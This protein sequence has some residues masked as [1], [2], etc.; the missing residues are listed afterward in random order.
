MFNTVLLTLIE[1][2][3]VSVELCGWFAN[4]WKL[5]WSSSI[6]NDSLTASFFPYYLRLFLVISCIFF[7]M[8][9]KFLVTSIRFSMVTCL[10]LS[11][12]FNKEIVSRSVSISWCQSL[13]VSVP[14]F[15]TITNKLSLVPTPESTYS[16]D[17]TSPVCVSML[18]HSLG[19]CWVIY[20]RL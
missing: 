17:D 11:S 12:S 14:L 6:S 19:G 10:F 9:V 5:W 4:F 7:S 1:L 8:T 18:T 2:V 13:S 20:S 16:A 3:F 15:A